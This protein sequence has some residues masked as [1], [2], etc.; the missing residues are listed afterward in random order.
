MTKYNQFYIQKRTGTYADALAA[1]GLSKMIWAISRG[2][3]ETEVIEES[4]SFRVKLAESIDL[5]QA[6]YSVLQR[7]P[8]FYFIQTKPEETPP[9]G[10]RTFNYI[11]NKARA[12]TLREARKRKKAG[13]DL[14]ELPEPPRIFYSYQKINIL[15]GINVR[16]KLFEEIWSTSLDD[17]AESVKNKLASLGIGQLSGDINTKFRP[18]IPAV[19][20]FNPAIGKGINRPKPD[21]AARASLPSVFTDWFEEWLRFIGSEVVLWGYTIGDD[22]K[23]MVPVPGNI[24]MGNLETLNRLELTPVW[25][26]RKADIFAVFD[27][28]TFLLGKSEKK[29]IDEWA[30][31]TPQGMT[32]RDVIS[33]VQTAYFKSLGSARP[34]SNISSVGLPDWFQIYDENDINR[35]TNLIEEHKKALQLLDEDKHEEASLLQLYRDFLSASDWIVFLRFLGSYGPL[36]MSR[37]DK[38]R[39]IRSFQSSNLEVLFRMSKIG[40]PVKEI[41]ENDG[42]RGIARAIK[43]ATVSEQY[44]KSKGQQVFDIKYGLFQEIKR[45]AKFREELLCVIAEFVNEFNYENARREEQIRDKPGRRRKRV[46][47]QELSQFGELLDR[48]KGQK[49]TEAIA[50][51]LIA[52]ASAKDDK[53]HEDNDY[54]EE[55]VGI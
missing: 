41:I 36:I 8:L 2:T 55:E 48:Y 39:P 31:I 52:F 17:L 50:M 44:L 32:P 47:E 10:A 53:T 27:L 25:N 49:E 24:G 43:Q 51:L 16:N 54:T 42:F 34:V 40:L 4:G 33:S 7:E 23:M 37:R 46:S 20:V 6:D 18:K 38:N 29:E 19:Q 14:S 5:E 15:Q 28:V 22:I 21:S 35:W 26:S 9:A 13:Q 45:K 30:Y 1:V 11:E 12:D 3:L